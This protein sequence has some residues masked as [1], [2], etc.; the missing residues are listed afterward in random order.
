MAVETSASFSGFGVN[1]LGHVSCR[2]T[3]ET[4]DH[5]FTMA[6]L[7]KPSRRAPF[8]FCCI[9]MKLVLL[10]SFTPALAFVISQPISRGQCYFSSPEPSEEQPDGLILDNVGEQMAQ[11]S[12]K[13]PTSEAD[14]VAAARARAAARTASKERTA[15]DE[16]WQAVRKQAQESGQAIDDWENSATEAGN[17]DS[18]ILLPDLPGDENE[19]GDDEP[20]L[21]LF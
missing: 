14:Y 6:T 9:T 3:N 18:Q 4:S 8:D 1:A 19:G 21:L 2:L 17:I 20:K 16:D 7:A 10:L 12:S 13:Y 5:R 15:K 11:L